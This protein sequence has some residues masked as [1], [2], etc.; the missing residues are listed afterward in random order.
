MNAVSLTAVYWITLVYVSYKVTNCLCLLRKQPDGGLVFRCS[1]IAQY[2]SQQLRWWDTASFPQSH[3]V[4]LT[5]VFVRPTPMR[6]LLSDRQRNHGWSD[7]A[8]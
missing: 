5:V 3:L 4:D 6:R 8:G 7:P 2:S 1:R